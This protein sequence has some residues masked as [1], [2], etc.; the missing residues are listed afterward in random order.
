MRTKLEVEADEDGE[1]TTTRID[2]GRAGERLG[3]DMSNR[4]RML[5]LGGC[6]ACFCCVVL[7]R[8]SVLPFRRAFSRENLIA[9]F[10]NA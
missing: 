2:S 9:E 4:R 3:K 6:L 5:V 8:S 1:W 7:L 10:Y